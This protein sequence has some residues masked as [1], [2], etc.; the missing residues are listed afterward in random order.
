MEGT[1]KVSVI[2][3]QVTPDS[4]LFI[5]GT[6]LFAYCYLIILYFMM[7]CLISKIDKRTY[8]NS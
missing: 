1:Q 4:A 3:T 2:E 7:I 8:V 6:Y 5:A